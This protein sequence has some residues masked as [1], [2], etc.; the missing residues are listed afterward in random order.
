MCGGQCWG[1]I[2]PNGAGKT[3]LVRLLSGILT[4]S[5]GIVRVNDRLLSKISIRERAKIMAYLP[6]QVAHDIPATAEDLVLT[7][8]Y[9]HRPFALFDEE[10]DRRI[11]RRAMQT[12]QTLEFAD[13]AVQTLSGGEAQRVYIAAALA[14]EPSI[15]LV[16]EPTASLDLYYQISMFEMLGRLATVGGFLVVVVTHD[17]NLAARYCTHILLLDDG[18]AVAVG[19]P[20][21]VVRPEVLE[22]VYRVELA[23]V[24]AGEA[25][26]WLVPQRARTREAPFGSAGGAT[27]GNLE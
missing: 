21:E 10:N 24:T 7:G 4:P 19:A 5:A 3:T 23:G 15:L 20:D 27:S 26:R 18:R 25:G 1:I 22:S 2:G 13:R 6:Q 9:P 14:Q 11:A 8:R 16:D 12:T 17:V